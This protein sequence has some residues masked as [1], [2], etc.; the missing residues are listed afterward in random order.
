MTDHLGSVRAVVDTSTGSIA[1]WTSYDA[2]GNVL[3]DSGAGFQPFGFG[4]GLTDSATGLVR[5]GARDYDPAVGRW[6]AKDPIGFRGGETS[7][8]AYVNNAPT[9]WADPTG[10]QV[11]VIVVG[12]G[13]VGDHSALWIGGIR[14]EPVLY[15]P[16]GSYRY[17]GEQRPT[18]DLFYGVEADLQAYVDFHTD[19]PGGLPVTLYEF[20]LPPSEQESVANAAEEQGGFDPMFCAIAISGALRASPFFEGLT[21]LTPGGLRRGLPRAP[22]TTYFP[23]RPAR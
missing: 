5:F 13:I 16:A 12:E 11:I 6:T 21:A 8:Y 3:A 15:D 20:P 7:L 2:W 19:G 22:I 10:L 4:G 18:G 14:G 17:A 23:A 9:L 1:Q